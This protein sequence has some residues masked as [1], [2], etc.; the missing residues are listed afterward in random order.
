MNQRQIGDSIFPMRT[1]VQAIAKWG[2]FMEALATNE[3]YQRMSRQ[4]R[5]YAALVRLELFFLET[6]RTHWEN[7]FGFW[8]VVM[9]ATPAEALPGPDE[10]A[11][12]N[13]IANE[14]NMPLG[15]DERGFMEMRI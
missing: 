10:V 12:L 15:F 1:Q 5:D 3:A 13:R 14:A 2:F 6:Y 7:V 11:E 8:N 9:E 4:T